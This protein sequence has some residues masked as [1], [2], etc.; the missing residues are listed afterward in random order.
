MV[1]MVV[2]G[3]LKVKKEYEV[4]FGSEK[5]GGPRV[6]DRRGTVMKRKEERTFF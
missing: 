1:I 3:G 5:S 4:W 6:K 2:G